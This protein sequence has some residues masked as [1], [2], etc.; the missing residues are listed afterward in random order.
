MRRN[1]GDVGENTEGQLL[2]LRGTIIGDLVDD[3]PYGYKLVL[4]DGS[5]P[6]QVFIYPGTGIP[7]EGPED[8]ALLRVTCFSNQY[9][10][11]YECDPRTPADLALL[12]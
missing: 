3:S 1:T 10:T 7:T 6:I 5:G 11:H 12:L 2:N 8:G 4:D 9:A